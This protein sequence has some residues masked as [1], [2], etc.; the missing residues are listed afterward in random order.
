MIGHLTFE[1]LT[2]EGAPGKPG[3]QVLNSLILLKGPIP[4]PLIA[5]TLNLYPVP[6]TRSCF[7]S[8][9]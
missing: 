5:A 8:K 4:Q 3:I 6:G 9:L 2:A 7:L 1:I